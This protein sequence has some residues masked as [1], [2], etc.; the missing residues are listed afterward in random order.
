MTNK[1]TFLQLENK[2]RSEQ[3]K[4]NATHEEILEQLN[5]ILL[6]KKNDTHSEYAHLPTLFIFGLPHSLY[7]LPYQSSF[8][9]FP[10]EQKQDLKSLHKCGLDSIE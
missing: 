6:L 7:F 2:K 5:Q 3:F 9:S 10:L 4:K 1:H 8:L